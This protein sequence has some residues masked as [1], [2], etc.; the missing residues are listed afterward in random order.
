[1]TLSLSSFV[2]SCV[3]SSLFFLLVSLKFLLPQK[4]SNSVSRL[5]KGYLKFKRSFKDISRKFLRLFTENF[6]G[7]SRKFQ[8]CFKE[9]SGKFQGC[10]KK[11]SRMF[12]GSFKLVYSKYQ[13]CFKE[14]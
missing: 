3:F 14:F 6:M 11:V 7:V 9:V 13:G 5:F 12:Q 10:F 2:R 1:M 4:S 8:E